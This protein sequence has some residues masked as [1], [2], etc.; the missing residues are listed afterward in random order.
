MSRPKRVYEFVLDPTYLSDTEHYDADVSAAED[1]DPDQQET[2]STQVLT[3]RMTES[4]FVVK[5]YNLTPPG[6]ATMPRQKKVHKLVLDPNYLSETRANYA[7]YESSAGSTGSSL[8]ED[9]DLHDWQSF[10]YY[11]PS[12]PMY[13]LEDSDI[14]DYPPPRPQ[15]IHNGC[16]EEQVGLYESIEDYIPL[17]AYKVSDTKDIPLVVPVEERIATQ[18]TFA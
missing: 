17:S 13:P 1:D 4:H 6:P 3:K 15:H 11:G 8:A 12:S 18:L 14:G 10:T 2:N 9:D 5:L 16:C 7:D